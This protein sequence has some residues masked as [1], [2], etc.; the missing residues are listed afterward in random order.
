MTDIPSPFGAGRPAR[1]A[2]NS[3]ASAATSLSGQPPL[4]PSR[5]SHENPNTP[6]S[7]FAGA[8]S[9]VAVLESHHVVELRRGDLENRRVLNG[10]HA[11][12]GPRREAERRPRTD[13]LTREH[14]LT[15]RAELDLRPPFEDVPG[16]VL[17]VVELKA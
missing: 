17:H 8:G 10:F 3:A 5:Y 16:L 15:G 12:H 7:G 13:D 9:P 14:A 11:V 2:P 1:N 4:R 6:V